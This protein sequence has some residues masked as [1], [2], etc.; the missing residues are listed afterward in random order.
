MGDRARRSH[1]HR[2]DYRLY[3]ND[4]TVRTN[5]V[6]A[7]HAYWNGAAT[8]LAVEEPPTSGAR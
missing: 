7:T 4:L 5:H 3:A 6:D 2:V 1:V 8:Y